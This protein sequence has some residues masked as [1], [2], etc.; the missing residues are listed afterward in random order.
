MKKTFKFNLISVEERWRVNLIKELTDARQGALHVMG[1][2]EDQDN[3]LTK[4]E[5]LEI[6]SYVATS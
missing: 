1:E 3:L 5:M 6:I 4:D 2:G